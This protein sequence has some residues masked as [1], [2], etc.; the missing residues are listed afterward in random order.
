AALAS[1]IEPAFSILFYNNSRGLHETGAQVRA[2]LFD[3]RILVRGGFYAGLRGDPESLDP[4]AR[5]VNPSGRPLVAGMLRLNL[6]GDET[7]YVYPGIYFDG[8]SRAS[9]GIGGQ[10]QTKGSNTPVT[11]RALDPETGLRNGPTLT[12]VNDY[13]ALAADVFADIALPG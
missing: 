3:R 12:A 10:F 4:I 6:I 9:I 13:I 5:S 8:K 1:S 11:S 7:G 2:L